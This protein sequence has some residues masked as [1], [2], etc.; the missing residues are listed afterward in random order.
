MIQARGFD[1]ALIVL[2]ISISSVAQTKAAQ[3]NFKGFY[4]GGYI[5]S[6]AGR[7]DV[8][9]TTVPSSYPMRPARPCMSA[10]RDR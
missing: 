2:A 6:T 7:S 10:K 9:T 4:I 8:S 3:H 1:W 5:G